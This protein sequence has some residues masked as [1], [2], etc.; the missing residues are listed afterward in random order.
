M[1]RLDRRRRLR[2]DGDPI[3]DRRV[4]DP[5]VRGQRPE[6]QSS[7]IYSGCSVKQRGL[8][9]RAHHRGRVQE[10]RRWGLGTFNNKVVGPQ[11]DLLEPRPRLR[12]SADRDPALARSRGGRRSDDPP[13]GRRGRAPLLCRLPHP[14]AV[15][16][17]HRQQG[18]ELHAAAGH[19]AFRRVSG[20][21]SVR[22]LAG[23]WRSVRGSAAAARR[24]VL[25]A[26]VEL[27]PRHRLGLRRSGRRDGE[28]IGSRDGTSRPTTT[29]RAEVLPRA[30]RRTAAGTI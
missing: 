11:L 16:R 13:A 28:P 14:L 5:A 3:L 24:R 4:E 2:A 8:G 20:H 18:A 1:R 19:A 10:E 15:V 9:A 7:M 22:W 29:S 17:V 30:P 26:I 25:V 12:R 27:E 23:R 21:E 6:R